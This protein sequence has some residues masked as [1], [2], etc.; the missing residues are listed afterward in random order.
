MLSALQ[1]QDEVAFSLVTPR[2]REPD[3][4]KLIAAYPRSRCLPVPLPDRLLRLSTASLPMIDL[5]PWL[6]D[7]EWVYAPVEQPVTTARRLAVTVHDLYPFERKIPGIPDK[8]PAGL[9]WRLRIKRIVSRA[10]LIATVSD[11]TRSRMLELFDVR[12]PERIVVIGNGGAEGFTAE[13]QPGD[14][15]VLRRLRLEPDRYVLFPASL[16]Y[17]KG[18]D[19]LLEV[20]GLAHREQVNLRFVVIGRRHDAELLDALSR[21]RERVP[22]LPL[23][24]L[25]YVPGDQLAALYRYARATW[26][27]FRYEGFGIPVVEALASGC[28][29]LISAHP[30]LLEAA[31]GAATVV[32]PDPTC[33]LECLLKD[34]RTLRVGRPHGGR[35]WAACAD[36]LIRAMN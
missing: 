1:E 32:D 15:D 3:G 18:G 28:P 27:P 26:F 36:R 6:D 25:G 22:A 14:A 20:A 13:P 7:A 9:S 24:L 35:T 34:V 8:K 17:R 10:D 19:L 21:L 2:G 23:E 5:D 33:V 30:A 4:R 12:R 11:F 31:G 16:T 29:L